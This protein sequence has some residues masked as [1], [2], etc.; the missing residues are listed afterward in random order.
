M[1]NK[2]TAVII[3]L[4]ILLAAAIGVVVYLETR[5]SETPEHTDPVSSEVETTAGEEQTEAATEEPTEATVGISLPT[6]DPNEVG[7]D[8]TWPEEETGAQETAAPGDPDA[9]YDPDENETP[10][11]GV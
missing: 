11:M 4:A 10:E 3:V 5:P 6:E 7:P 2:L 1:K 9:T 8:F